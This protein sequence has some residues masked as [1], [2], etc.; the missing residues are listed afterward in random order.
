MLTASEATIY[1]R[2]GYGAATQGVNYTI[3]RRFTAFRKDLPPPGAP[4]W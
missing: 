3:D 1:E 4:V 2:F